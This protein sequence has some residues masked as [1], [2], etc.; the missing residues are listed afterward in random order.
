MAD[1]VQQFGPAE[2]FKAKRTLWDRCRDLLT[3]YRNGLDLVA[4]TLLEHE[5]IDG[6]EVRRLI[7]LSR[8]DPAPRPA[9]A[10]VYTVSDEPTSPTRPDA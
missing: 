10:G 8:A 2:P 5:T 9:P 3:E 4:R 6:G 7:E 1:V